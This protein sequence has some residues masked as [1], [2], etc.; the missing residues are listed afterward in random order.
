MISEHF[1]PLKY[2][3]GK[4]KTLLNNVLSLSSAIKQLY[5]QLSE[6]GNEEVKEENEKEQS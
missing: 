6:K 5:E 4:T 3:K 2:N 1:S